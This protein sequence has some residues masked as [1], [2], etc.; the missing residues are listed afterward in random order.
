MKILG[1]ST[2]L[3]YKNLSRRSVLVV[4]ENELSDDSMSM[5]GPWS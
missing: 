1:M 5:A 4:D 2:K 3:T